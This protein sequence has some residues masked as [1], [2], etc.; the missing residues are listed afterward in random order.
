[1]IGAQSDSMG[2]D[3]RGPEPTT[4]DKSGGPE[5]QVSLE[6]EFVFGS[7]ADRCAAS[8]AGSIRPSSDGTICSGSKSGAMAGAISRILSDGRSK[9]CVWRLFGASDVG[10]NPSKIKS[11]RMSVV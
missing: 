9:S 6:A 1:M 3:A 8:V 10:S 7:N 2:M 5:T 11:P 4:E